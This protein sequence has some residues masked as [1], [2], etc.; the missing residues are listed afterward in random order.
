MLPNIEINNSKTPPITPIILCGGFGR[1]LWPLSRPHWPKPFLSFDGGHTLLQMTADR[2]CG[3]GF[4]NPIVICNEEHR[5]GVASQLQDI[6]VRPLDII[7]EPTSHGTTAAIL[8]SIMRARELGRDG[9]I[10]V[11]PSDQIVGE[12]ESFQAA[13]IDAATASQQRSICLLGVAPNRIDTEYGHIRYDP[14]SFEPTL[15]SYVISKL[16]EKP[17]FE[18]AQRLMDG[19][20]IFWNAG[21][22]VFQRDRMIAEA[23]KIMPDAVQWAEAAIKNANRD[24][25]FTRLAPTETPAALGRSFDR[26]IVERLTDVG[27]IRID[28]PWNDMGTW[29]SV[30]RQGIR[31]DQGNVLI[32][33]IDAEEVTNSLIFSDGISISAGKLD[34]I[35]IV[36]SG[37]SVLVAPL[38][39]PTLPAVLAKM[40]HDKAGG[41]S[42]APRKLY[43]MW[44]H[45]E[46][47]G[48]GQQ[49]QVKKLSV[50]PGRRLS[51]QRHRQ[52]SEHWVVISGEATITLNETV[53]K[54]RPSES[55]FVPTGALH[56]LANELDTLLVI[57][58][59]Q[60]GKYLG[61]DDI[62]R[63]DDDFFRT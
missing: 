25:D 24:H 19:G 38:N 54:L 53:F 51:L 18:E 42:L 55:T 62:E 60:I 34:G 10:V 39:D 35:T 41:E 17:A 5:F 7:L 46:V 61:E 30:W 52:R 16:I 28:V 1:R 50:L 58:E 48:S 44:G 26:D 23:A 9:A 29:F 59:V 20:D 56:R 6:G 22:F 33:D 36:A 31:T 12:N 32:G 49:Y 3:P 4:N 8:F 15:R 57:I 13:V 14:G 47:I 45:F 27:V 11:T 37:N 40:H 2:F 21:I 63:V 43:R